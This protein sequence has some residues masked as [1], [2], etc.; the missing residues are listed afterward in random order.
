MVTGS[1][2]VLC[3]PATT[4]TS[5]L[6][7]GFFLLILNLFYIVKS[8]DESNIKRIITNAL[9]PRTTTT[10]VSM[11]TGML[12]LHTVTVSP[13]SLCLKLTLTTVSETTV[14]LSTST[15]DVTSTVTTVIATTQMV[16]LN[17]SASLAGQVF[18]IFTN[19]FHN[20]FQVNFV[21]I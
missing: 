4:V 15:T 18:S 20:I 6:K 1:H 21:N 5:F 19:G 13:V 7:A 12:K 14:T 3:V 17:V 8:I 9:K 16:T 2:Q 10:I 11:A